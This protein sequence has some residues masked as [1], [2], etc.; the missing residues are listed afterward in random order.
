[1]DGR[2]RLGRRACAAICDKPAYPYIKTPIRN[3]AP[4]YIQ[5]SLEIVPCGRVFRN[6]HLVTATANV[7][8]PV[9]V[10]TDSIDPPVNAPWTKCRPISCIAQAGA[11]LRA[12]APCAFIV[13]NA[14]APGPDSTFV[15]GCT[16]FVTGSGAGTLTYAVPV[17]GSVPSPIEPEPTTLELTP[18]TC[19][20]PGVITT[21]VR[22]CVVSHDGRALRAVPLLGS[23]DT[24]QLMLMAVEDTSGFAVTA[25]TLFSLDACGPVE[26][27]RASRSCCTAVYP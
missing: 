10:R 14:T 22:N 23:P 20:A 18:C 16:E 5:F 12:G 7:G 6:A 1:M 8:Q 4:Y 17:T 25:I 27:G 21:G 9:L 3:D 19:P 13:Y 15:W 11:Q 2:P 26:A 24:Y